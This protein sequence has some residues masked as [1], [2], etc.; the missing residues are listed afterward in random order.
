MNARIY[1]PAKSAM[2]SGE[3]RTKNWVLEY[4]PAVKHTKDPLMGW[5][6]S[7]DQM[8]Q[9]RLSFTTKDEA[10]AY[11]KARGITFNI[12]EP[13]PRARKPKAYADNF[14]GDRLEPWTH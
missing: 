3:A 4:A 1:K 11:A 10:I 5:T 14:K 13:N 8:A 7:G 2:Q 12:S 6:S 9:I